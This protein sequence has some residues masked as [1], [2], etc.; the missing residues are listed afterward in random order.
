MS[1]AQAALW[2]P[3]TT[4]PTRREPG[5]PLAALAHDEKRS[6]RS[7]RA[8]SACA[9]PLEPGHSRRLPRRF[10]RPGCTVWSTC[11]CCTSCCRV[12]RTILRVGRRCAGG[13]RDGG[14]AAVRTRHC[15]SAASCCAQPSPTP[16]RSSN[17]VHCSRGSSG[18]LPGGRLPG[19][20]LRPPR[21][22][23]GSAMRA[24][25]GLLPGG[26]QPAGRHQVSRVRASQPPCCCPEPP[27]ACPVGA[28]AQ[29]SSQRGLR[30]TLLAGGRR[31]WRW[32]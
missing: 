13:H 14:A 3:Q 27:H 19:R 21:G 32:R 9:L 16:A 7:L 17:G 11:M 31:G 24:G 8:D 23:S 20:R 2:G 4:A 25:S 6:P 5:R 28:A 18:A 15:P 1:C 30:P 22:P 12:F 10:S 29:L 26:P